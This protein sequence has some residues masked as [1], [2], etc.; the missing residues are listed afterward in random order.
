[1]GA[2]FESWVDDRSASEE[3]LEDVSDI[4]VTERDRRRSTQSKFPGQQIVKYSMVNLGSVPDR[5]EIPVNT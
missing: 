3:I 5:I 4:F 1:M 2:N